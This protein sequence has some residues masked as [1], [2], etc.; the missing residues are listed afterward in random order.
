MT[1]NKTILILCDW[2]LP[3]FKAGGPIQSIATLTQYLAP[4]FHFKIIT[5][6]R[7]FKS[8]QP[9]SNV[10][11]NEWTVYEGREVFYV[12]PENLNSTFILKLIQTTPHDVIYLNSLFSK[13]F[14]IQ[15]LSWRKQG[16]LT[17]KVVL[18]P[19]GMLRP[20]ALAVKP[21]KKQLFLMYAKITGL[22]KEV[23]WQSTS[24]EETQ[25]IKNKIAQSVNIS[26]I[27]N[28][29]KTSEA[30]KPIIKEKN[31]LN[32][33][34]IGRILDV[35]NLMFACD[36]IKSITNTIKF[37]VFGPIEDSE[38]WNKCQTCVKS[39][40]KSVEFEYKGELTQD[41]IGKTIQH[42]H[43]LFLPTR[44]ENFGHVIVETLQ[45]S[46]PVIISDQ[47]PWRQL[48]QHKAGFDISLDKPNEFVKAINTLT[49]M[50]QEEYD[51]WCEAA[52]NYIQARL[53]IEAIINKYINLFN[54]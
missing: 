17:S 30:V 52:K 43:A 27:S 54:Q 44:T 22:F 49:D 45:N 36:I 53:N 24:A 2:F 8:N 12:S 50:N 9:Y 51:R 42:Y 23:L 7:D 37:H 21:L 16:K 25:E 39:L 13:I 40:P 26:E 28:F 5:T 29:P 20:G 10:I 38:Y 11:I 15:P 4:H 32:I 14:T 18:A 46:R 19:R 31:K 34:F 3:G 48:M 35:K 47:T 6:D 41:E 1:K 33:C